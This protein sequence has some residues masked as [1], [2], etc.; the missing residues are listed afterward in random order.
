VEAKAKE[1]QEQQ[2]REAKEEEVKTKETEQKEE[3]R[4]LIEEHAK[5]VSEEAAVASASATKKRE[6]ETAGAARKHQEEEAAI[7]RMH[8]EQAVASKEKAGEAGTGTVSL[9]GST[10][11]IQ[12]DGAATVKLKCTGTR[13]CSG[14]LTLIA[15]GAAKR[16]KKV[17]KTEIGTA[18][19]SVLAGATKIIELTLNA[20]GKTLLSAGHGHLAATL[21]IVKSS[22]SPSQSHTGSVNLVRQKARGKAKK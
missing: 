14:K 15:T 3:N 13:T 10:I 17:A 11:S 12:I 20:A 6:E 8:E 7:N 5:K 18:S 21:S 22:P 9:D 4:K 1:R 16:G 19:F 2:E